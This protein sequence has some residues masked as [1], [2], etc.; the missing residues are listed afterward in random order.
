MFYLL[1]KYSIGPWLLLYNC[2]FL[3]SVLS[4]FASYILCFCLY[5]YV[6]S[7]YIFL[8]SWHFY[9]YIMTFFVPCNIVCLK[10]VLSVISLSTSTL[11]WLL[12][13]WNIF[14]HPFAFNLCVS[15]DLKWVSYRQH[16]LDQFFFFLLEISCS[17][18][19]AFNGIIK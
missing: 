16:K 3:P 13:V 17:F 12:F 8:V 9:Q 7:H 10:S 14:S 6:Y 2:L 1:L 5:V 15:L 11:F 19:S 18:K 4:V